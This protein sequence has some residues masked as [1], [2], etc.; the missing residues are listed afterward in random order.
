MDIDKLDDIIDEWLQEE[1][2]DG[3]ARV[4]R[5]LPKLQDQGYFIGQRMSYENAPDPIM[6]HAFQPKTGVCSKCGKSASDFS[7]GPFP[8]LTPC[9]KDVS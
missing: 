8:E 9:I 5:L 6:K 4:E 1:M 3:S 7:S 2:V